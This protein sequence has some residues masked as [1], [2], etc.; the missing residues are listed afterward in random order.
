MYF[1]AYLRH[2]DSA[3]AKSDAGI[4]VLKYHSA[5]N[6]RLACFLFVRPS[7]TLSMVGWAGALR[8]AG[9]L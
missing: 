6:T 5:H 7:S 4:G 3:S 9:S 2:S 1:L 8:G